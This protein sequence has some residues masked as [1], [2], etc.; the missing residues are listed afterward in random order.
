M[1][2]SVLS[3]HKSRVIIRDTLP[4]IILHVICICE[5][6]INTTLIYMYYEL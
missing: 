3:F 1:Y 4:R 5:V 2:G 6:L